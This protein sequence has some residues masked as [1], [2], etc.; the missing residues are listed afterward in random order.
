MNIENI[1][2]VSIEEMESLISSIAVLS[3]KIIMPENADELMAD[4]KITPG[5]LMLFPYKR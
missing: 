5:G 1:N 2:E 4:I 3:C